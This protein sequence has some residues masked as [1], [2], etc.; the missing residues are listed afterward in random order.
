MSDLILKTRLDVLRSNLRR[1]TEIGSA[2]VGSVEHL[3]AEL[4]GL[5]DLPNNKEINQ[6]LRTIANLVMEGKQAVEDRDPDTAWRCLENME[7]ELRAIREQLAQAREAAELIQSRNLLIRGEG[8]PWPALEDG[9]I[10]KAEEQIDALG[11]LEDELLTKAAEA[12]QQGDPATAA[13]L[14]KT[15]W[16][17][18]SG[19]VNAESDKV[20]SEYL[21][22]LCGLALRD[23]GFD[24][25]M[26]RIADK[27]I[28]NA[29]RLPENFT[30]DSLTIPSQREAL[31]A[32]LAKIVRLGFP[33]WTIWALPLAAHEFGH[34]A[35]TIH[36]IEQFVEDQG[37]TDEE[38]RRLRVCLADAFATYMMGPAYACAVILIRLDP[39]LAFAPDDSRLTEKRAQVVLAM[40]RHMNGM[41]AAP[42]EEGP[43]GVIHDK[44]ESEWKEAV[45]QAG[46]SDALTPEEQ[47]E[48]TT[49]V[50]LISRTM[51]KP[52]AL[53]AEL[54]PRIEQLAAC[55]DLT[56]V[57]Q[58]KVHLEDELRIVLNAAWKRR[59]D[60]NDPSRVDEVA[61][62]A[63]KLWE[64]IE[65]RSH[66][67]TDDR[68]RLSARAYA[69]TSARVSKPAAASPTDGGG[70][71]WLK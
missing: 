40:L 3:R 57:E 37:I 26:C 56:Q 50:E 49:W 68:F 34:V 8:S 19:T 64:R 48:I 67:D 61:E 52:R 9:L 6:P 45:Q 22:F 2:E 10:A 69:L 30:W 13:Q 66:T 39:V 53:P 25:G 51:G 41:A 20:F 21:D 46:S 18:Y 1:V 23:T 11:C 62:A 28:R 7:G 42:T 15:A 65:R 31:Q 16:E 4:R 59:I 38:S 14:K 60:E 12:E 17:R 5:L 47:A 55:L 29:G 71:P 43:Y 58:L 27:L 70:R 32:T 35:V 44:L 54:W 33:E 36:K 63:V 24:Q